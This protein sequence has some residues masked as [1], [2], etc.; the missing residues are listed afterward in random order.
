MPGPER[1]MIGAVTRLVGGGFH[2][3]GHHRESHMPRAL[4][5]A[6]ATLA[7][8]TSSAAEP[9]ASSVAP[10]PRPAQTVRL[11][12]S[13]FRPPDCA[14]HVLVPD[15]QTVLSAP[16]GELVF[17]SLATGSETKRVVLEKVNRRA[18]GHA[19]RAATLLSGGKR[20]YLNFDDPSDWAGGV[21]DTETGRVLFT[22]DA[23]V[24]D[25]SA[26]GS[27]AVVMHA[28]GG[29]KESV[30]VVDPAAGKVFAEFASPNRDVRGA[31][32]SADGTR[33]ALFRYST[34]DVRI[35]DAATGK[36]LSRFPVPVVRGSWHAAFSPNGKTVVAAND[37][38]EP[39]RA[40]DVATGKQVREFAPKGGASRLLFSADGTR[41]GAIVARPNTY[42]PH[43]LRVWD[44]TTGELLA[45]RDLGAVRLDL[46]LPAGKPAVALGMHS[47]SG[48]PVTKFVAAT[49]PGGVFTLTGGH[50]R[51]I[52][53]IHFTPDGRHVLTADGGQRV[54]RWDATTGKELD[55][56]T[57][58]GPDG[59]GGSDSAFRPDGTMIAF[60]AH[61]SVKLLPLMNGGRVI[62]VGNEN[63]PRLGGWSADGRR[64][65]THTGAAATVIDTATQK[66][67]G[68]V[69]GGPDA[70]FVLTPD[71]KTVVSATPVNV[72]GTGRMECEFAATDVATGKKLAS[73]RGPYAS[74]SRLTPLA[75][76]RTVVVTHGEHS[77]LAWD[78]V[79]GKELRLFKH[80][81]VA[82]SADG[83]LVVLAV[84]ECIAQPGDLVL[85]A[86]WFRELLSERRCK[87]CGHREAQPYRTRL[88]VTEWAT[89]ATRLDVP[90]DREGVPP[91]AFSAD[92]KTLAVAEPGRTTVALWDVSRPAPKR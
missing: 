86:E 5:L 84:E 2:H 26:D 36:E 13:G 85:A 50:F 9:A 79:T 83:K 22:F 37:V 55:R 66:S 69:A 63:S 88:L 47:T 60:T 46:I 8:A 42:H 41:L 61:A 74:R 92:G 35:A 65:L 4:S 7:A 48:E 30:R 56:L 49:L 52:T 18:F 27:R 59:S 19:P 78:A 23:C 76:N 38:D 71:G 67:V 17:T 31:A 75:D 20:V 14:A 70:E 44:A 28:E 51:S 62:S 21:Y 45:D 24:Y 32:I 89:G 25:L 64:F 6:L 81:P 53:T 91:M 11:G 33:V 72:P 82:V 58:P 87:G 40:W 43:T 10:E 16:A 90:N 34:S 73:Y 12:A 68:K 1:V 3:L 29:E 77:G 54:V 39:V 57:G 15:G 80:A